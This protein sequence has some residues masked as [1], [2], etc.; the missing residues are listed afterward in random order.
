[1]Y[2][3]K[4]KMLF[5]GNVCPHCGSSK[6]RE[7]KDNDE[8]FLTEKEM[9]WGEML[10]DMLN[11]NHIPFYYKRVQGA[12]LAMATGGRSECYRFFVPYSRL[13][14]AQDVTEG[15]FQRNLI[16]HH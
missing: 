1:M 13:A 10:A 4:C 11:Q 2:C 3:E 12:A 16:D 7:P 14:L 6:V 15:L 5:E 9:I 8:C